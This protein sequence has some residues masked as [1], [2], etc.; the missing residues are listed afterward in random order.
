[1]ESII[2]LVFFQPSPGHS[3]ISTNLELYIHVSPGL[4]QTAVM[5]F[6]KLVNIRCEKETVEKY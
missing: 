3:I 5:N 6:D 1:M 2:A 4:Q